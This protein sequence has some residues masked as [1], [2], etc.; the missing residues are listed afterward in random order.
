MNSCVL[1]FNS[2]ENE[3]MTTACWSSLGG[4]G[5]VLWRG[6][7]SGTELTCEKGVSRLHQSLAEETRASISEP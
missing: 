6:G 1:V 5:G 3:D 2:I 4:D 7:G